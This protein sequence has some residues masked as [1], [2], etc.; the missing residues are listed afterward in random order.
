VRSFEDSFTHDL[1]S[2]PAVETTDL[3]KMHPEVKN[4]SRWRQTL[5]YPLDAPQ[6]DVDLLSPEPEIKIED[7]TEEMPKFHVYRDL[8]FK[9]PAYEWLVACLRRE[10]YLAPAEP[11]SMEVIR[12]KILSCLL[13]TKTTHRI[14]RKRSPEPYK[15]TF[16]VE[17][18][19]VAF[20]KEQE[21]TEEPGRAIEMAI[22]LTGSAEDA[23]ALTC[24]QYLCQTWPSTGGHIMQLIKD[25][26]RDRLNHR[27]R[28]KFLK[29]KSSA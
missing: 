16:E 15:V 27:H 7:N 23:Q 19:P 28:C 25:V 2:F 10:F 26:V 21:Y 29:S 14:S 8:M 5:H 22:T 3:E 12:E 4:I 18:D 20:V 17:W 13:S 6:D 1:D 24:V 11:N 9:N